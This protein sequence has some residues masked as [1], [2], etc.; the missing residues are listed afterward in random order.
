MIISVKS[1]LVHIAKS[2]IPASKDFFSVDITSVCVFLTSIISV[3][4]YAKTRLFDDITILHDDSQLKYY[5]A[6][7]H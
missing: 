6:D 1:V 4:W 7:E 3:Y 5:F 2:Q